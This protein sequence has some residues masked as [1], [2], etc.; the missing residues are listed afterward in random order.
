VVLR[1]KHHLLGTTLTYEYTTL[2]LL[3]LLQGQRLDLYPPLLIPPRLAIIISL[4]LA[5]SQEV[6][7]AA[8]WY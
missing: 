8:W 5:R 6:W 4:M 1:S 7:L 2:V 3:H